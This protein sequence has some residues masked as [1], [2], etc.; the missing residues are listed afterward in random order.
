MSKHYTEEFREEAIKQVTERG[1]SV[2]DVAKR[3]SVPAQNLYKWVKSPSP[4]RENELEQELSEIRR[5]NILLKAQLQRAQ[6]DRDILKTATVFIPI[7]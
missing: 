7:I 4:T 2:N 1:Y 3:L 6:E 5:E